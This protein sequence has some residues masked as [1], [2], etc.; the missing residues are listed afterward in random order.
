MAL[1]E[2]IAVKKTFRS[3]GR[4]VEALRGVSLSAAAG[5]VTVLLG[6]NGSGKSTAL[7]ILVGLMGADAGTCRLFGGNPE[8]PAIRRR[9]GY[10]PEGA[11]FNGMA[12][13]GASLRFL[14]RLSGLH[15]ARLAKRIAEVAAV[16]G[17]R[18]CLNRPVRTYSKG[19][20]QRLG[21]AQAL[22]HEPE[23]LILDEPTTGLDPLAT[24]RF[25]ETLREIRAGGTGILLCTHALA[26]VE[27]LCDAVVILNSGE[28]AAQGSLPELLLKFGATSL[29]DLFLRLCASPRRPRAEVSP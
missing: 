21:L 18:D 12:K 14:G 3:S 24:H 10:M 8:D 28:V 2:L 11:Y 16:T 19:E 20:A 5:E 22:L 27:T 15:G 23:V 29:E 9:F 6:P 7:K 1:I 4:G 13:G 25:L 26:Q 17:I